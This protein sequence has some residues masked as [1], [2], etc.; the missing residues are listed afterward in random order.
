MS[1]HVTESKRT[2]IIIYC[3]SLAAGFVIW[4]F[5]A[6]VIVD[7]ILF[8]SDPFQTLAALR[9]MWESG[10][11]L[12]SV[13]ASGQEFVYGYLI[14]SIAG[15]LIGILM[16]K[17]RMVNLILTPYVAGF[18]ATPILALSPVVILWLGLGI[19]SKVFVV[20]M[21]VVFTQIY[22]TE[23][24]VRT[25]DET[26]REV[27]RAFGGSSQDVFWR[28]EM[29]CSL[30]YILAGLRV[31]VGRG[32]T[33]VVVAELFGAEAGLGLQIFN[34]Q[35]SFNTAVLFASIAILALA[36]VLLTALVG[37][38]ERKLTPWAQ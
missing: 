37:L 25:A 2:R 9:R 36:G 34:A 14:G 5:V 6:R 19:L 26:L 15:T 28:A 3:L 38:I 11:L 7:N 31:G 32:L 8:L 27:V 23:A 4:V 16:A 33:G 13:I 21:V 17:S 24:G 10:L 18:N 12:E 29:W 20:A 30:P 35:T 22:N 1:S